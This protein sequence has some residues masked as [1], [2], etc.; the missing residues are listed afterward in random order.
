MA[1]AAQT[2]NV[3][4]LEQIMT[5]LAGGGDTLRA[6]F[7]N[8]LFQAVDMSEF[9][10]YSVEE[11]AGLASKAFDNMLQ[12][13]PGQPQINIGE[14]S[15]ANASFLIIDAVNDDMPFLLDSMLGELR[16]FGLNAELVAH[17]IFLVKRDASGGLLSIEDAGSSSH[18]GKRESFIHLH[19]RRP[20]EQAAREAIAPALRRVLEQVRTVVADFPAMTARLEQ[21]ISSY[22][23]N[24]P[25]APLEV[26]SESI[27]FLKWLNAGNFIFL[28]VREYRYEMQEGG[29]EL[30]PIDGAGLGLLRDPDLSILRRSPITKRLTPESRSFFL[31]S[32]PVIVAKAN[33]RSTVHRRTHMDTVGI[34]LYGQ[35][36][37]ISGEMRLAGL[38]TANAY[39]ASTR[40]IPLLRQK[41]EQVLRR[42]GHA[43]DSYSG[44]ALTNV[45]EAFPRDE[46]FQA[47]VA[48]LTEFSEEIVKL[49]L[50]PRPRVFVRRD[51]FGRFVSAFVYVP[52]ERFSTD[53][54]VRICSMLEQ[55]FGGEFISFTPFFPEGPMV[56]LHIVIWRKDEELK[57]PATAQLEADAEAII[58][59]WRDRFRGELTG[60]Y[61]NAAQPLIDKYLDA[62]P[63][64]YEDTNSP[65]RGL[66]D[67]ARLEK[68]HAGAPADIDLYFDEET[69]EL[70]ATLQQLDEPVALSRRVPILENLGFTVISERTFRLTPGMAGGKRVVY[71]HDSKLETAFAKSAEVIANEISLEQGFLAVWRGRAAN[72]HFNGLI[73]T[74]SLDWR[75]VA[76]LRAYSAYLRQ[77]GA[78]FGLA[79]LAEVLNKY[80]K[81]AKTFIT[82]FHAMFDP[83]N[84]SSPEQRAARRDELK[85]EIAA[86]LEA[87]PALDEERVLRSYLALIEATLRTNFYHRSPA[88]GVPDA[89]AFKFRS[90]DIG[91]LPAPKP[92]AEIFV[93]STRFEGIHLRGGTIARGGLRW[94]DRPQDFRTEILSLA[95]AQQVKNTV[96]VP[97]GAKGGF[98]PP[99][100]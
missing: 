30:V 39:N 29:S 98:V 50:T 65:L 28:G 37:G 95:K 56:R 97:Q 61:G 14:H 78:P 17:P 26:I 77:T 72:D 54:R 87:I 21:A 90:Q 5:R 80:P 85:A 9:D 63:A 25:P 19:I 34:K 88:G 3:G 2:G 53:V 93:Y 81:A 59:T 6:I 100:K 23:K 46:L 40:T 42:A 73:L 13:Q 31:N 99:R 36:G 57:Q 82:L 11:L 92:Y 10:A 83:G 38:F 24:P 35:G 41:V 44:R 75:E 7:A 51:E 70:R 64:G 20:D 76:V 74:G 27:Q 16:A 94:S 8:A 86:S 79:Y 49:D 84:G 62:F 60:R 68:L 55:A 66:E 1:F 48:Q 22:H 18:G 71:L 12:R 4:K 91:W 43:P 52:R 33:S 67:V 69:K 47:S 15:T 89:I 96:I 32:P 58:I 45:L